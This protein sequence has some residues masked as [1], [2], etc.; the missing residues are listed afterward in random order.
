M[1]KTPLQRFIA[2]KRAII[3]GF[4]KRFFYKPAEPIIINH[5]YEDTFELKKTKKGGKYVKRTLTLKK[6][7]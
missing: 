6:E 7:D 1:K 3:I 2:R 4:F 5:T